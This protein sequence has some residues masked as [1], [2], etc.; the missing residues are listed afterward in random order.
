MSVTF[1]IPAPLLRFTGGQSRVV[2]EGGD[3][4]AVLDG[5]W[6][7][8]PELQQRMLTPSGELFPYLLLFHNGEKLSREG[9]ASMPLADGDR[10]ELIGLAEGG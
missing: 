7:Q 10:L 4:Q 5:V 9:F 2:I 3:V 8:F 6:R 1:E